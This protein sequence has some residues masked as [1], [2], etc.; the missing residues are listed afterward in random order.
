MTPDVSADLKY[1]RRPQPI[2][3]PDNPT[4]TQKFADRM[5]ELPGDGFSLNPFVYML[6][7]LYNTDALYA[8]ALVRKCNLMRSYSLVVPIHPLYDTLLGSVIPAYGT[9]HAQLATEP[10]SIIMGFNYFE[11]NYPT[12][13]SKAPSNIMIRIWDACTGL[14]L[15][16]DYISALCYSQYMTGPNRQTEL[17][18]ALPTTP[19]V[20]AGSGQINVEINNTTTSDLACQ[21]MI[22]VAEPITLIEIPGYGSTQGFADR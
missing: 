19:R 1:T 12:A 20:L 2:S 9:H 6:P 5:A 18:M 16:H 3:L 22:F 21:L 7:Y 17:N 11:Y 8:S 4:T 13:I 10:G 15:A 14:D